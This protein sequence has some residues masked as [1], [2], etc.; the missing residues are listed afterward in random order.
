MQ[1]LTEN[2]EDILIRER[3][4][5]EIFGELNNFIDIKPTL[6][7]VINKL[8]QISGCSSISIRLRD[9]EDYPYLI[10]SGFPESFIDK[11]NYLLSNEIAVEKTNQFID[12]KSY[13]ECMCGAIIRG[14]IDHERPYFTPGGTFWTNNTTDFLLSVGANELKFRTRNTCNLFGYESVALIPIR[15]Q[16]EIIGLIQVNDQRKDMF[17]RE[18]INLLEAIGDQ[19]GAVIENRLIYSKLEKA[20][21]EIQELNIEIK[22]MADTDSLTGIGNRRIFYDK[23]QQEM[24]RSKRYGNKLALLY[25]DIDDFK[26]YN[27]QFGHTEGDKVLKQLAIILQTNIRKS[28]I[29]YRIGG[30]EFAVIC[31]E[32]DSNKAIEVAER[33]RKSFS[34]HTFSPEDANGNKYSVNKTISIGIYIL[35]QGESM[36]TLVS[37]AD[38]AMYRAKEKGKNRVFI[39]KQGFY[40]NLT[41]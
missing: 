1:D 31:P 24:E 15:T 8:K 32:T 22:K 6:T 17:T 3:T 12:K 7:T 4:L 25:L 10:H 9:S 27:D 19:I 5:R 37:N 20:Y 39:I 40:Y 34:S 26:L 16:Q 33:V 21:G 30:E 29:S 41:S 28:D 13:L 38:R 23:L 18:V 11:E 14:D 35:Q 2:I 36:D